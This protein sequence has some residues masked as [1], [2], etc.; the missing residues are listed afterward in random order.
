MANEWYHPQTTRRFITGQH[1]GWTV[2]I[3]VSILM[4]VASLFVPAVIFI[5]LAGIAAGVVLLV[6]YPFVGL[7]LYL[8]TFVL[9]PGEMYP[10]LAPLALER[11][12]GLGVLIAGMLLYKRKYGTLAIPKDKPFLWMLAFFTVIIASIAV[13][14]NKPETIDSIEAFAK[15]I[16]FFLLI[17]YTIDTRA[18]FNIFVALF[19]LLILREAALSF[20]DYY[21]GGAIY[22]MGIARATGRGSFGSGA[23]SLAATLVFAMPFLVAFW[24]AFNN[25]LV[26]IMAAG[27]LFL[28]VLMVINTGSRGGLLAM[29]AAFA[30]IVFYSRYRLIA[31]VITVFM[32][33][34]G[35]FMLPAQYQARYATLVSGGDA[36]EISTGRVAIWENGIRMFTANPILGV[37]S[38]AFLTANRSGM[39]GPPI[40]LNPHSIYIQL[41]ADVG[42]I[43]FVVWFGF[44]ISF[45]RLLLKRTT[46]L[47]GPP[48][49]DSWIIWLNAFKEAFMASTLALLVSGATA[50]NL[51]RFNWYM[52]A[53]LA[54]VMVRV[55]ER[56]FKARE[57]SAA[58][59]EE[60]SPAKEIVPERSA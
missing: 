46:P 43:G 56:G 45:W 1:I 28:L 48:G 54:V 11:I 58:E 40:E 32:L 6:K 31:S 53:A 7:L 51:F 8:I 10:A 55:F 2:L 34:G 19:V 25:W 30:V 29:L 50:H 26:R 18:K 3:A 44:L 35:W 17:F 49:S 4:A 13:S 20:S 36:D 59:A 52:Y 27:G 5:G 21:G 9:R 39:Y 14:I 60:V 41:L 57:A 47:R 38:G 12:I 16:V 33:I 42:I 37:G 24:K 15:L 22:R 23:N